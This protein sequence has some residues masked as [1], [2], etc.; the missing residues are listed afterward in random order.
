MMRVIRQPLFIIGFIVIAS[1]LAAS[2]I[3]SIRFDSF[4]PQTEW[5]KDSS[6]K[7]I[8]GPPLEPDSEYLFG[9]DR[10]GYHMA[11]KLLQGAKFTIGAAFLTSLL[12][13]GLSFIFGVLLAFWKKN[14]SRKVVTGLASSFYFVPQSIIAYNILHPILWEPP[15]GFAYS[16]TERI[17]YEIVMLALILIPTTALLIAEET[18]EILKKEFI[19]SSITLGGSAFFIFRKHVL[20]HLRPRLFI[21]F[22][23]IVVQV[24][25]IIAH[26]GIF[27]IYFG[28]TSVCYDVFCDPPMPIANEWS[29]L[30][31][32][33]IKQIN[34][35]WWLA[36]GPLLCF[37]A[38]ILATNM[39]G[40]GIEKGLTPKTTYKTGLFGKRKKQ[41][42]Q[43]NPGSAH[44]V[45]TED[46]Q[47]VKHGR[48]TYR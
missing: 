34:Y 5:V 23:R 31:G 29:G 8:A 7:L 32:M 15:E 18:R 19:E 27:Q 39:M 14:Q 48:S 11:F 41:Q 12:G 3:H 28:G 2:I 22:P 47:L 16:L 10:F 25:L 43:P 42:I 1:L 17:I 26:L 33:Y 24:L 46:F 37:T 38:A 6:G 30:L 40:A 13:F 9:T 45:K 35:Q 36:L 44:T 20:V 21:I 4:I